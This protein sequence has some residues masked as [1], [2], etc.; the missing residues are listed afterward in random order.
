MINQISLLEYALIADDIYVG[1]ETPQKTVKE[2]MQHGW[3]RLSLAFDPLSNAP[4][5]A[6]L[7][8]K[9][10]K[11]SQHEA[12]MAIRGTVLTHWQNDI[13]DLKMAILHR[14]PTEY[15]DAL[16]YFHKVRGYLQEHFP[17]HSLSLTGHSL[18]G[19]VAKLIGVN[20]HHVAVAFNAP[21]IAKLHGVNIDTHAHELI[22]NINTR[23][24]SVH[25][26]GQSIGHVI[27]IKSK[28]GLNQLERASVIDAQEDL[29]PSEGLAMSVISDIHEL[30]GK[31]AQH[32]I[33]NLVNALKKNP[34]IADRRIQ[35]L[36]T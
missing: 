33:E 24:D 6:K 34:E 28:A 2:L 18:G 13:S 23:Q 35:L 1:D 14:L 12:V 9:S 3:D 8:L 29:S 26:L 30:G 22:Y 19:A 21:G 4:F 27:N 17:K 25:E 32:K 11:N 20:T 36:G 15:P 16:T 7:Y 5:F 10:C 31:Y